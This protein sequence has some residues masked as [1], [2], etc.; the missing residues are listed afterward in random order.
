MTWNCFL[1]I[2]WDWVIIFFF[3]SPSPWIILLIFYFYVFTTYQATLYGLEWAD[4]VSNHLGGKMCPGVSLGHRIPEAAKKW[5]LQIWLSLN[6][7][8]LPYKQGRVQRMSTKWIS[9]KKVGLEINRTGQKFGIEIWT[10]H[11]N[12]KW[13]EEL[14]SEAL[15]GL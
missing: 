1:Y 5:Q 8:S 14:D 13:L 4:I 12:S 15:T 3:N 7:S 9:L 10:V 11:I 6:S 2:I